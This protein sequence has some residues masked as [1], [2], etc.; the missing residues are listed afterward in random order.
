[1]NVTYYHR[2]PMPN[3][4]SIERLFE[5]V[6]RSLPPDITSRVHVSR[7]PSRGFLP[8]F[9]NAVEAVRKQTDV[10]HITGD[11]HYLTYFLKK[12]KTVLTIHDCVGLER[13]HGV[14]RSIFRFLWYW[15]PEKRSTIITVVS[16]STKRDL[17]KHLKCDPNK[18]RVVHN[19]VSSAFRPF[20]AAFNSHRPV[21]LQVGTDENKNLFRLAQALDGI[22]CHL[23]IVGRLESRQIEVLQRHR[24]EYSNGFRIPNEEM[25]R[26]YRNCDMLVFA[27]TYE[28][29]GLP[30][31][32]ANAT[33]RPV[34]TSNILSMPEVAG[35]AAC[36]VNPF[37]ADSIREGIRRV[38]G[39][40]DYR[41]DLI[42]NGLKN[43]G[44]FRPEAV[45]SKYV[46]LYRELLGRS[47]R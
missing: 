13:L 24:I 37:D 22:P 34:V 8:R 31:L 21:I 30:I 4:H 20:P 3:M 46:E 35:D 17:L 12:E 6:R 44:R 32:E 26:E 23:R 18:I 16:E 41:N 19:C 36:L 40:E 38:I 42:R 28:G 9:Y 33:G 29:F 43:A 45:A 5:D 10:N 39:D 47:S 1:M 25:V 27:S 14:R 2:N 15:L 7:F 11:V